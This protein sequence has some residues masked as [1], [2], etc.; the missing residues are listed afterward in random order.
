MGHSGVSILDHKR[1]RG[2]QDDWG[3]FPAQIRTGVG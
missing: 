2:D 1:R 3:F